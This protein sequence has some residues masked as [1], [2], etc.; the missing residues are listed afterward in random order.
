MLSSTEK[1]HSK[2]YRKIRFH[3]INEVNIK[4]INYKV[5]SLIVS[6]FNYMLS[7]NLLL[8]ILIKL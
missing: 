1:N 8:N 6:L 5:I 2:I 3:S 4:L 7:F